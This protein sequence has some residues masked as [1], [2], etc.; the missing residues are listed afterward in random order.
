VA[1]LLAVATCLIGLSA[2][3]RPK[4]AILAM[5]FTL[6][7]Q[8][9]SFAARNVAFALNLWPS[10]RLEI[11]VTASPIDPFVQGMRWTPQLMLRTDA[12]YASVGVG[13]DLVSIGLIFLLTWAFVQRGRPGAG[14]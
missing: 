12:N 11:D 7:P 9:I 1:N 2:I 10:F 8:A 14:V 3:A 4:F 5:I 6:I 13:I